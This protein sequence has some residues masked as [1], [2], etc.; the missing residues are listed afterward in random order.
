MLLR[1][2]ASDDNY[3]AVILDMRVPL[4]VPGGETKKTFGLEMLRELQDA[5]FLLPP[6][7]PVIIYTGFPDWRE[8]VEAMRLGAYNYICKNGDKGDPD[9]ALPLLIEVCKSIVSAEPEP[10]S[11][12][13]RWLDA[14]FHLLRRDFGGKCVVI[15]EEEKWLDR[16]DLA[17]CR[18]IEGKF[19]F[20]FEFYAGAR[21][22]ILENKKLRWQ[23]PRI[24]N[25]PRPEEVDYV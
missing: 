19:V 3:A 18:E 12:L 4:S 10:R 22:W 9:T 14:V 5:Y 17:R 25:V 24:V 8:C 23:V 1:K 20:G 13:D 16:L 11:D 21:R 15:L 2:M 7:T 6:G